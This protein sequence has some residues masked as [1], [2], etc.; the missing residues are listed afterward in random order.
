M[1]ENILDFLGVESKSKAR[2]K[3]FFCFLGGI[4]LGATAG[5]LFAPQSG[6]ETREQI[7]ETAVVVADKTKELSKKAAKE[8]K[9]KYEEIKHKIKKA[10]DIIEENVEDTVEELEEV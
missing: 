6:H 7:K 3:S 8:V 10:E 9:D 1:V 2:N 4:A 5:L